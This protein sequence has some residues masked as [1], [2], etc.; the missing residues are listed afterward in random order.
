MIDFNVLI[1]DRNHLF[2]TT[3]FLKY[4]SSISNLS[5]I[6][7]HFCNNVKKKYFAEIIF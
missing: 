2:I 6:S 1:N 3:I 4:F 5:K 7:E